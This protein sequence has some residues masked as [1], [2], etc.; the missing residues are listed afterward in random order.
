MSYNYQPELE[1]RKKIAHLREELY[2]DEPPAFDS[3]PSWTKLAYHRL[4][5][6]GESQ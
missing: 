2:D 3:L 6:Q 1:L 5:K 4:V